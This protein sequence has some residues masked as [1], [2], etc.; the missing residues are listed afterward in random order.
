M[1]GAYLGTAGFG[2]LLFLGCFSENSG[3]PLGLTAPLKKRGRSMSGLQNNGCKMNGA[4]SSA[5]K[6]EANR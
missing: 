3:L 6:K 1:R 5:G 4:L 2:N